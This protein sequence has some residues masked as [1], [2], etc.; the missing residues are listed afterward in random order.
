MY[1]GQGF[2]GIHIRLQFHLL[3]VHH[4]ECLQDGSL[5]LGRFSSRREHLD[6][7]AAQRTIEEIVAV[8]IHQLAIVADARSRHETIEDLP[9]VERFHRHLGESPRVALRWVCQAAGPLIRLAAHDA[10]NQRVK[11]ELRIAELRG[12]FVQQGRMARRVARGIL[13][14]LRLP[15]TRRCARELSRKAAARGRRWVASP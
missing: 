8:G 6:E 13:A 1:R 14:R 10:L 12:E 2:A 15:R 5:R 3:A 7:P 9:A 11:I 4:E